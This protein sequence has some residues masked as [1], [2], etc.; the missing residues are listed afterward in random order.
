LKPKFA[1]HDEITE[2]SANFV[3]VNLED[4]E[5][6]NDDVFKPDGGYIPRILFMSTFGV[7]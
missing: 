3:M 6:P 4:E 7:D 1:S 5:E 2:L